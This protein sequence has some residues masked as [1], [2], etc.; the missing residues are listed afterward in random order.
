[1]GLA[2]RVVARLDVKGPNIV[3]GIRFEGLRV[4]GKPAELAKRYAE[5][6]ADELLYIDTVASLYGRNQLE[7]LIEE[8]SEAAFVPITV[9][10]GIQSIRDCAR[11]FAAG[12]DKLACNTFPIRE[13]GF[14][15][16]VSGRFGSQAIT[17]SIEAKRTPQG[18]ECYTDNGREKTG[19]CA[20]RWAHEA[21]AL[22]AGEL[23]ITSVDRDGTMQGFDAE[24]LSHIDVD[25][26]VLAGGGCG[27]VGHLA[28]VLPHTQGVVIGAALHYGRLTI[29]QA[30][31]A[32][33]E[34]KEVR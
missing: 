8:T 16:R 15:E 33:K 23:L 27:S 30:K 29:G 12:A 4:V 32:I 14:I 21:A 17:V 1:M 10:G 24:L 28:G 2:Y 18:W 20:I 7:S 22:G 6:G 3:K 25:I 9:A 11:L 26:P 13:P 31:E 34:R 5:S 19:K